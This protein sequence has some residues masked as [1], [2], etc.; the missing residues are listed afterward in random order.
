MISVVLDP[1]DVLRLKFALKNTSRRIAIEI[2]SLP[3][4]GAV[5]FVNE[6]KKRITTQNFGGEDY[7]ALNP[8]YA[9]WKASSGKAS[10]FWRKDRYLF[11]S[12]TAYRDSNGEWVRYTS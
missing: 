8:R 1:K 10:G 9:A 2:V 11:N 3:K 4:R 7:P 5:A 12:L 6:L